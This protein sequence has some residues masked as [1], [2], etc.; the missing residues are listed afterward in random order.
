MAR[1]G[2]GYG[3]AVQRLARYAQYQE[4][5]NADNVVSVLFDDIMT[6]FRVRERIDGHYVFDLVKECD[7]ALNRTKSDACLTTDIGYWLVAC[8]YLGIL[9]SHR[10]YGEYVVQEDWRTK[11]ETALAAFKAGT[12]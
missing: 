1:G 2:N 4:D 7:R 3:S 10:L 5:E 11:F 9:K 8:K 6:S 12:F